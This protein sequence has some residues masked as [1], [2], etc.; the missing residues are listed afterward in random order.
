MKKDLIEWVLLILLIILMYF[1]FITFA[2]YIIIYLIAMG[3][4]YILKELQKI[5]KLLENLN[6]PPFHIN[7]RHSI[8]PYFNEEGE[9]ERGVT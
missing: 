6:K 3:L 1:K 5:R 2:E 9:K 8:S 7:C 4:E